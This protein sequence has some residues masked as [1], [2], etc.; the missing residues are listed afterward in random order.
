MGKVGE[1]VFNILKLLDIPIGRLYAKDCTDF[2]GMAVYPPEEMFSHG[3]SIIIV[4]IR[5]YWIAMDELKNDKNCN[6]RFIPYERFMWYVVHCSINK[7]D[8][9]DRKS[10]YFT[11]EEAHAMLR[12]TKKR[13]S[14]SA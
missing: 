2:N 3:S 7:E 12:G 8:M 6:V 1:R 9:F 4:A 11:T 13:G 5:D 10:L 14:V